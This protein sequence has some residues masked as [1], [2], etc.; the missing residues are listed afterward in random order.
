MVAEPTRSAYTK[1]VVLSIEAIDV[2]ELV[3]TPPAVAFDR[4]DESFRHI[5]EGPEIAPTEG[6]GLTS[7]VRDVVAVPQ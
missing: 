3:H 2:L 7:T 5:D 4:N 6:N 1:P